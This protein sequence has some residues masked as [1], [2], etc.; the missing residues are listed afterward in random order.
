MYSVVL[1]A[2]L[3]TGG[4]A[5]SVWP[6]WLLG[7]WVLGL[8]RMLRVLGRLLGRVLRLLRLLGLLWRLGRWLR[9]RVCRSRLRGLRLR[10][11]G[12][13]L[14][15][16]RNDGF[17]G[18]LR[19]SNRRRRRQMLPESL[20]HSACR[21]QALRQRSTHEERSG[22]ASLPVAPAR[23][24]KQVFLLAACRAATRRKEVRTDQED[25]RTPWP[26][27]NRVVHRIG[28]HGK[29]AESG[30]TALVRHRASKKQH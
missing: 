25:L 18:K 1:M 10:V 22:S 23:P 11:C 5:P 26:G 3:S 30:G 28:H 17:G 15:I 14:F 12:S 24:R 4:D 29:Q 16:A 20:V 2:A 27:N 13:R 19:N 21:R 9:L 6:T 7:R 8:L